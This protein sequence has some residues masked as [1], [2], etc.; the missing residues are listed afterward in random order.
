MKKDVFVPKLT[1]PGT[2]GIKVLQFLV[3]DTGIVVL[4]RPDTVNVC[5][6]YILDNFS[7]FPVEAGTYDIIQEA[8]IVLEET[9]SELVSLTT[10]SSIEL[11]ESQDSRRQA[12]EYLFVLYLIHEECYMSLDAFHFY[13]KGMEDD[14]VLK[15]LSADRK[16][17]LSF[18]EDVGLGW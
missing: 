11:N 15:Y 3:E 4:L 8:R 7:H 18:S 1:N 12:I 16:A 9:I 13:L 17:W 14:F 10:K 2:V 5:I 6:E